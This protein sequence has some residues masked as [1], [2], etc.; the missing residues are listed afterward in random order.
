MWKY[1]VISWK[2]H[3][4]SSKYHVI[5]RNYHVI[6]WN[7]HA[8]SWNYH[9]ILWNY[10]VISRNY[11]IILWNYH[12]I[13]WNYH[14]ISWKYHVISWNYRFYLIK[15]FIGKPQHVNMLI[16]KQNVGFRVK[17][18]G[19]SLGTEHELSLSVRNR[20]FQYI[21]RARAKPEWRCSCDCS[22][23]SLARPLLPHLSWNKCWNIWNPH[24]APLEEIL[25]RFSACVGVPLRWAGTA[26]WRKTWRAKKYIHYTCHV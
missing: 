18:W 9:V 20:S 2:Y 14:V 26:V 23:L 4:I 22:S 25:G 10:H 3:V 17:N 19:H 5:S 24:G 8:I 13:S 15:Q 7:Y 6:S 16:W 12:V 11:H 21:W 1:Q